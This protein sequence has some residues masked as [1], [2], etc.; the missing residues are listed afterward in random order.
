MEVRAG[1]F[2]A[3][4]GFSLGVFALRKGKKASRRPDDGYSKPAAAA[5]L[6][7]C[8][9]ECA[10]DKQC[11]NVFFLQ[12][13]DVVWSG[14]RCRPMR[15]ARCSEQRRTQVPRAEPGGKERSSARRIIVCF[16]SLF[17]TIQ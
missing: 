4:S 3:F 7:A 8:F 9:L 5:T 12:F 17:S 11:E 16:E 6:Q 14:W 13:M 1:E 10:K 2:A 15:T